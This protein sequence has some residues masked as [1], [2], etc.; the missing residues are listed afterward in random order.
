MRHVWD[1]LD[2]QANGVAIY[3][4]QHNTLGYSNTFSGIGFSMQHTTKMLDATTE[5]SSKSF[6]LNSAGLVDGADTWLGTCRCF[7]NYN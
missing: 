4:L 3:E 5:G 2:G 7:W 1:D 6:A